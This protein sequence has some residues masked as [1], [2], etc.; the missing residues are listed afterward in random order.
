MTA[1]IVNLNNE[2]IK[3][4][5]QFTHGGHT[6]S[7][8]TVFNKDRPEVGYWLNDLEERIHVASC[9]Q[10]AIYAIDEINSK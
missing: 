3:A 2:K 8:S 4:C 6:V 9:V 7:C 5:F 1:R 10:A